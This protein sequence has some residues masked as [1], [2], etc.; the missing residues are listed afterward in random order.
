MSDAVIV[1]RD[2]AIATV[3]LNNP[4]KRNALTKGA[5]IQ[6]AGIMQELS[7]DGELRCVVVRGAGNEAFAA[8]RGKP[9]AIMRR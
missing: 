5:W 8:G 2:G 7:A 9:S 4:A 1:S 3:T 6:L